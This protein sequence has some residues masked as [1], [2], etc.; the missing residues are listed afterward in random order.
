MTDTRLTAATDRF[1]LLTVAIAALGAGLV[2]GRE[3][4]FGAVFT[5]DSASYISA[6]RSLLAGEGLLRWD[7]NPYSAWPPLYPLLLAAASLGIFDPI[8]VAGPLN[9]VIFGLTIF[10]VG[11][12]L[13]QRLASRFLA[14]WSCLATAL[15]IPLVT[16]SSW[17]LTETLLILLTT[18]ALIQTDRFLTEGKTRTLVWAAVFSALALQSR[19]IGVVVPVFIGL[20]LLFQRGPMARRAGRVTAYSLIV[21][22][23]TVLWFLRNL[24]TVGVIKKYRPPGGDPLMMLRDVFDILWSWAQINSA[25]VVLA[26]LACI[27]VVVQWRRL[28]VA[29][30]RPFR[31]FTGFALTYIVLLIATLSLLTGA[32]PHRIGE[33]FMVPVYIPLLIAVVFVL[34]RVLDHERER[35]ML[36][37][38]GGLPVVRTM[39]PGKKGS[40]LAA[41]VMIV[42]SLGAAS[43]IFPNVSGIIKANRGEIHLAL[44][45][46]RWSGSE[47]MRYL[48]EN[49]VAGE[50]L[51]NTPYPLSLYLGRNYKYSSYHYMPKVS[52]AGLERLLIPD[53]AYII[54]FYRPTWN[55]HEY[56]YGGSD[57]ELIPGLEPVAEL[58]DGIVFR[59]AR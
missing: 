4:T 59:V 6:A 36:G 47:T 5:P 15:A 32:Y 19:Y 29:D 7:G 3:F 51:S 23:P 18:L 26:T 31:L 17:A 20:L 38:V 52:R 33:R 8:A 24:L 16:I 35:K 40:L 11:R 57:L 44:S 28:T 54:W 53:G 34:D 14:A 1:T 30:W 22:V 10:I 49:P 56:V 42:L 58:A 41:I 45:G 48:R 37:S 46:P 13:R 39:M 43:Q 27:F 12:Y 55:R 2:L 50:I 25:A 21:A 9:A